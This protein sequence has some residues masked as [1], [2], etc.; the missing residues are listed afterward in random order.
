MKAIQTLLI[1]AALTLTSFSAHA[2]IAKEDRVLVVVSELQ[3]HGP[4]SLRPLYR[5]IED[6]TLST[7]SVILGDDYRRIHYLKGRDATVANFKNLLQ[8]LS[9]N[10]ANRAIDVIFS[11]HGADN[12]VAF[13]EGRVAMDSLVRQVTAVSTS[14]TSAQVAT[15]KRKL[16]M[17]YNL[18]CFGRSHNDD[19]IAMGF[20]AS[21][22][23]LGINANSEFEYP[24]VLSTWQIGWDFVDTF[25]V[26]N[27]DTAIAAADTPVILSG[28]PAKSKKFFQGRT[29]IKIDSDPM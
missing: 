7:T 3:E 5:V 19:F 11:L 28:I 26:T 25:H 29:R 18:S 13:Y 16:R 22:G 21:V 4:Q 23:S 6:L 15:M 9:K 17:V 10:P 20:D 2:R 12:A 24:S 8:V 27:T 14:M 1:T